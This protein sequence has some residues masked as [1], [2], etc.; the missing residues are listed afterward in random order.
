MGRH[1]ADL[2]SLGFGVLFTLTGLTFLL[3]DVPLLRAVQLRW[4]VPLLVLFLGLWL[5]VSSAV[6]ERRVE[7]DGEDAGEA[8]G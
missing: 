5:L 4:L 7:Q 2:V 3:G 1:P 8:R 6:P